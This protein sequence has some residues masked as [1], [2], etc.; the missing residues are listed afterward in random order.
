MIQL[1]F[2]HITT[3]ILVLISSFDV[4]FPQNNSN[5][6]TK[7]VQCW[8]FDDKNTS[9]WKLFDKN[10]KQIPIVLEKTP[11]K[12]NFFL[13]KLSNNTAALSVYNITE[14]DSITVS[15]DIYIIGTWDGNN[16]TYGRDIFMLKLD[17]NECIKTSFSNTTFTQSYP[18]LKIGNKSHKAKTGAKAINKL[19]FTWKE[20]NRYD[21]IMDA[22]YS[23]TLT[24]PHRNNSTEILFSCTLRDSDNS[25]YNESWGLDNVTLSTKSNCKNI[26]DYRFHGD[27]ILSDNDSVII[28]VHSNCD[29]CLWSN[30]FRGKSIVIKQEGIYKFICNNSN[31]CNFHSREITIRRK[32]KKIPIKG[33]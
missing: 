20:H 11:I 7:E 8:N 27:S 1:K 14:H 32:K 18:E 31:G 29:T 5:T 9:N 10:S 30:G 4:S 3:Y 13:G 23:I 6:R 16:R 25:L 24:F 2:I 12:S 22:V 15:F 19:G 21:G 26:I 33:K 17:T 28:S